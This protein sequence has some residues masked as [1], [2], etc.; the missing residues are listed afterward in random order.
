MKSIYEIVFVFFILL[1]EVLFP[2]TKDFISFDYLQF[3]K[4]LVSEQEY[5]E[6]FPKTPFL[7]ELDPSDFVFCRKN[8]V[9][10]QQFQKQKPFLMK[11]LG[12]DFTDIG[13]Y[14]N[15]VIS[16]FLKTNRIE[17]SIQA[18]E[19]L[20]QWDPLFF[21]TLYNLG[22]L[23]YLKKDYQKSVFYFQKI[24]YFF[25]NYPRAHYYL[26]KN[27]FELR[28]DLLGES[29]FRKAI[30]LH[31][32]QIEYWIGLIDFF[33][34]R[35]QF[36]KSQLYLHQAEKKFLSNVFIQFYKAHYLFREKKYPQALQVAESIS[37]NELPKK[38]K[39]QLWYLKFQLYEISGSLKRAQ[40]T[41]QKILSEEEPEFFHEYSRT[42]FQ[43]QLERITKL[44]EE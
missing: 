12:R 26:G 10:T 42:F 15:E 2:Q 3:P 20:Y 1:N 17:V 19:E 43:H 35:Q 9:S 27:Y 18:L 33:Y 21:A 8:P 30:A 41:L 29:H 13:E 25:P 28:Q 5:L 22:R 40:A 7:F 14:H 44:L 4:V 36:Q 39:L 23:Y 6:T 16:Y 11:F 31:P 38:Q 37:E 34:Q 32:D 24:L